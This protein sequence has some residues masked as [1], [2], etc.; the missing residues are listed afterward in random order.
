MRKFFNKY[1]WKIGFNP[2]RMISFLRKLPGF[3]KEYKTLK[4]QS[5]KSSLH[6]PFAQFSL[7]LFDKYKSGGVVSGHYFHQD[8]WVASKIYQDKPKHHID[9]GSR[10]DGFVAH[11]ATFRKIEVAD[12]R[13]LESNSEN[14]SY[15]QLDIMSELPEKY[16]ECT[17]SLSCLHVVEHFGLGRYGDPLRWDGH[18]VGFKNLSKMLKSGG[19]FYFSTPIGPQRIE[20]N[21]HRVFAVQ[22]LLDLFSDDF[23]IEEFSYVDDSGNLNTKVELREERIKENYGCKYGC[24]IFQLRKE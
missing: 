17:D 3:R 4:K 16:H 1:G 15:F 24:G 18:V 19:V 13:K 14:I 6:F 5:E 11:V 12:I 9:V 8:L 7:N 22:T 2:Y 21:A 10:V 20:F 23:I